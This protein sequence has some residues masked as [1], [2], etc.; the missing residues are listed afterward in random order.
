[1][2]Y[3]V[4]TV[5]SPNARD[6]KYLIRCDENSEDAATRVAASEKLLYLGESFHAQPATVELVAGYLD[7]RGRNYAHVVNAD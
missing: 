1:M 7:W 5:S 6:T 2:F 4:V 3:F